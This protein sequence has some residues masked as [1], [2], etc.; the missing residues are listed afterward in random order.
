MF[1]FV[2]CVGVS[3]VFECL[4]DMLLYRILGDSDIVEDVVVGDGVGS[5]AVVIHGTEVG[6]VVGGVLLMSSMVLR[7]A[8]L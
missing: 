2:A 8:W 6:V 1:L 3:V 4:F 7:L 5:I